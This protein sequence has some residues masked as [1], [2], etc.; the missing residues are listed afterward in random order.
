MGHI[1]YQNA[2]GHDPKNNMTR[3]SYHMS[4][5]AH[6]NKQPEPGNPGSRTTLAYFTCDN[7]S[8]SYRHS[9]YRS[10]SFAH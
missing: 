8:G 6:Q 1:T 9:G 2:P 3:P 7:K 5:M 10:A 4:H